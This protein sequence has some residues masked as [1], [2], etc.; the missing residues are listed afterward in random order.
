[1]LLVIT[2]RLEPKDPDCR[3]AV[4][5]SGSHNPCDS[6]VTA[7]P[8]AAR[9]KY[10]S[11]DLLETKETNISQPALLIAIQNSPNTNSRHLF[12]PSS[13]PTF[14]FLSTIRRVSLTMSSLTRKLK[15][16]EVQP[17]GIFEETG[18]SRWGNRDIYP[19]TEEFRTY[20]ARAFFAYWG[21]VGISLSSYTL[22]ST[23]IAIGLNAAQTIGAVFAGSIF[24]CVLGLLAAQAGRTHYIGSVDSLSADSSIPQSDS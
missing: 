2:W 6:V 21:T 13:I 14:C 7:C 23:M 8:R 19:I 3:I 24:A 12:L 17:K 9:Y 1:M 4:P 18:T 11:A 5:I 10:V 15:R 20:N 22:G 16:F